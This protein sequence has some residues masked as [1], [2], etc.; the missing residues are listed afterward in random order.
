MTAWLPSA[1]SS[2]PNPLA[3]GC[4]CSHR[5]EGDNTLFPFAIS[6]SG[7]EVVDLVQEAAEEAC[8]QALGTHTIRSKQ[9]PVSS[10]VASGHLAAG[11]S[12]QVPQKS[13]IESKRALLKSPT[14]EPY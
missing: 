8:M 2:A 5:L 14:K 4:S 9:T 7:K 10:G 6:S 13:L 1:P 12:R 3:R 11:G